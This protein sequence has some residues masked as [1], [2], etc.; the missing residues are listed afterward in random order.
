[1]TAMIIAALRG[2]GTVKRT[3][4]NLTFRI[5]VKGIYPDMLV[6]G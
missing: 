3:G 1:M 2:L 6:I 5:R 4:H